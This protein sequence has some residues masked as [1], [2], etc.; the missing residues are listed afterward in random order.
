MKIRYRAGCVLCLSAAILFSSMGATREMG[1]ID[2][3]WVMEKVEDRYTGEGVQEDMH[4]TLD[5]TGKK[6]SRPRT[7]EVRWLKKDYGE[8]EKLIVHF[9]EPEYAR[10]T[11][12][13]QDSKNH[14][15]DDR[16]LFLP[17]LK[18][19]RRIKARD[20]Y[21]NFMGT[22]FTYYD[23]AEREPDEE[24][25]KL[26]QSEEFQGTQCYVVETTPKKPLGQGYS[27]KISWVDKERF[28]KLRIKYFNKAGQLRK[29]Y[30]PGE[31]R[32]IDG[33]WTPVRLVMEDFL[34]NHRT[35]IER[36]NI[37]YNPP[38]KD[39][40]FFPH[41]VDRIVYRDRVFSLLPAEERPTKAWQGYKKAVPQGVPKLP[42]S[43][44]GTSTES[45]S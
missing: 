32:E 22:D 5:W 34:S 2:G 28:I 11:T 37:L 39:E 33:I 17:E 43:I 3:L 41:N 10:G 35:V 12:L 27:K 18:L 6:S 40:L 23:L 30:D 24:N 42:S 38:T 13:L 16:W 31:W 36:T 8:N 19:I 25:H 9:I 26:L 44:G 21:T 4:L 20:E 14:A 15:D 29:Q 1:Q 7:L 45:G